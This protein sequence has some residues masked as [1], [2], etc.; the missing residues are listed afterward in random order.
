MTSVSNRPVPDGY[1]EKW[2]SAIWNVGFVFRWS[3]VYE[4]WLGYSGMVTVKP[5]QTL[6]EAFEES[7]GEPM[8]N[9]FTIFFSVNH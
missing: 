5:G 4:A 1:T 6:C 8:W 2:D 7:V 9:D 3:E